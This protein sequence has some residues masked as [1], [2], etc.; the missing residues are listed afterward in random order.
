MGAAVV[1]PFWVEFKQFAYDI[2]LAWGARSAREG[3]WEAPR[4][5]NF[6]RFTPTKVTFET[7]K[8]YPC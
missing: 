3:A 6:V 2:A 7:V 8:S 4:R 1:C 5:S